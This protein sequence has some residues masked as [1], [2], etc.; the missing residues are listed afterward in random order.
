MSEK[1]RK[2][3]DESTKLNNNGPDQPEIFP[4]LMTPAEA[5]M[6]L[7]LHEIGHNPTSAN[8]TMNYWREKGLL[9]ATKYAKRIWYLKKELIDFLKNK[10]EN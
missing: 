7:R 4:D 8:R 3:E 10:T 5:A 1:P 2:M 6:F 9:K